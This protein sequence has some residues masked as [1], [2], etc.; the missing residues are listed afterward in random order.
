M[1]HRACAC[2]RCRLKRPAKARDGGRACSCSRC[3][4]SDCPE[5]PRGRKTR[6]WF[7]KA[8]QSGW[9]LSCCRDRPGRR[10]NCSSR[11]MRRRLPQNCRGRQSAPHPDMPSTPLVGHGNQLCACFP[12]TLCDIPAAAKYQ[13]IAP[14][15]FLALFPLPPRRQATAPPHRLHLYISSKLAALPPCNSSGSMAVFPACLAIGPNSTKPL[16]MLDQRRRGQCGAARAG[17][18]KVKETRLH[19]SLREGARHGPR[20]SCRLLGRADVGIGLTVTLLPTRAALASLSRSV[21]RPCRQRGSA[22]SCQRPRP[23]LAQ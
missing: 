13:S 5:P 9:P 3:R 10:G 1:C 11:L 8:R 19:P 12:Q 17:G 2:H 15:R 21:Q 16:P 18:S 4:L 6:R 23:C 20:P 22:R 7:R 14:S